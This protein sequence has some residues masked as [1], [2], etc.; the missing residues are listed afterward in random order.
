[1]NTKKNSQA[2]PCI[3]SAA[4]KKRLR[5]L[6]SK[7]SYEQL[8][9]LAHTDL[10]PTLFDPSD[11]E[12]DWLDE[13]SINWW[14]DECE[15]DI[16]QIGKNIY[17]YRDQYYEFRIYEENDVTKVVEYAYPR[18]E[19]LLEMACS[20][21]GIK[22]PL[23]IAGHDYDR[24]CCI[25]VHT[26]YWDSATRAEDR[27]GWVPPETGRW[28]IRRFESRSAARRWIYQDRKSHYGYADIQYP[29]GHYLY[30]HNE[31][32]PRKYSICKWDW[33]WDWDR[34]MSWRPS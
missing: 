27:S 33:D 26:Y 6:L 25:W 15:Q 2:K 12:I 1:M 11:N 17:A 28:H 22:P 32:K 24:E 16:Y 4:D 9:A 10:I 5:P 19:G 31:Y 34:A 18:D 7:D 20:S 23:I 3:F 14:N 30:S 8:M 13:I 21:F 29:K